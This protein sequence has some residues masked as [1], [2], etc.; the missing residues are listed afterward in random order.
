[1]HY[2]ALNYTWVCKNYESEVHAYIHTY[3]Q[4][5]RQ[6]D[7]Q[8]R[9]HKCAHTYIHA[10]VTYIKGN[11]KEAKASNKEA[12]TLADTQENAPTSHTAD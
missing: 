3:I 9:R 7:R 10:C 2:R 4:T 1:M 11:Q 5:N 6:T 8:T 12:S